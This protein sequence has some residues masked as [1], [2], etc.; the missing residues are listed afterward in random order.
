[1]PQLTPYADRLKRGLSRI[2]T[3][4]KQGGDA[5]A[6]EPLRRSLQRTIARI[7]AGADPLSSNFRFQLTS[8]KPL[9]FQG[10]EALP[11]EPARLVPILNALQVELQPGEFLDLDGALAAWLIRPDATMT[12]SN[13]RQADLTLRALKTGRD[14]DH[15][16]AQA[17]ESTKIRLRARLTQLV[18]ALQYAQ[19][20][21][22]PPVFTPPPG[23]SLLTPPVAVALKE[24][25]PA[26]APP[27]PPPPPDPTPVPAA[28]TVAAPAPAPEPE[29][30][31]E[32][33][34]S[35]LPPYLIGKALGKIMRAVQG[36]GF[37][38]AILG[39][40]AHQAWGGTLPVQRIE[41][42]VYFEG[43]QRESV[44]GAARGEGLRQ[45]PDDEPLH[46]ELVDPTTGTTVPVDLLQAVSPTH[47]RILSR[48]QPVEIQRVSAK[49]AAPEDLILLRAASDHP[50][51]PES[52]VDLFRAAINRIDAAYLK[53]EAEAAGTFEQVKA[54]WKQAKNPS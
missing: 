17:A 7:S 21:N 32:P 29:A 13:L 27:P 30:P 25:T 6:I 3:F 9:L 26:P 20:D 53:K 47:K 54:A 35:G 38:A 50:G 8:G 16:A 18:T 14:R 33:E 40:V 45:A 44:L 43:P 37:R 51:H 5:E 11:L 2:D 34:P 15:A 31:P 12:E 39:D 1:M 49:A 46:L 10:K 24:E 4:P 48:A 23:A 52:L 42:L 19:S 28:P 36:T 41:V 22:A